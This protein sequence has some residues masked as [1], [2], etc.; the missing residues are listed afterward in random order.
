MHEESRSAESQP[1]R[2]AQ[3]VR[4]STDHQQYSTENQ[5]AAIKKYAESNGMIIVKTYAD[6]GKSGLNIDGRAA[7]ASLIRDIQIGLVNFTAVLIY[8]VSRWGRFQDVDESAHYEYICTKAGI[9]IIC[10]ESFENDGTPVSAMIKGIKRAMAGEYSRELSAKVF[11]GQCRLITLGYRQG[12]PAGYGLRRQLVG[13][14]GEN[15]GILKKGQQKS[16]Q[17][18][19]V[20]LVPG[21][22]E[23]ITVV[24]RIYHFFVQQGMSENDIASVL[25][26]EDVLTDLDHKWTRSTVHQVLTNEKYIGNNVYNRVSF[27]LKKHRVHNPR[28]GWIRVES[29]FI[30]VVDRALFLRAALIISNRSVRLSAEQMLIGLRNLYIKTGVLSG[31]IID[32][33]DGMPS[34]S[35]YRARFGSLIRAYLLVGYRPLRDYRYI[36]I[37]RDLRQLHPK[38]ISNIVA[39]LERIGAWVVHIKENALL[40]VNGEFTL[41]IILVR[42]MQTPGGFNRWRMRFDTELSPDITLAVRMDASNTEALDYYLLPQLDQIVIPN[43]VAEENGLWLDAYRFDTLDALYGI[44]ART[45]I[46]KAA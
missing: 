18:D 38:I 21:P 12:G 29:V 44:A 14:K 24:Q 11:A 32:E 5:T 17:T 7:L 30:P 28:E 41:S 27:K 43:K 26:A 16:L 19:R 34:S 3:Y 6:E 9:R 10:A 37:N 8:D 33:Q 1:I 31:L 22:A 13:D 36:E 35:A 39:G 25:N 45:L 4:M 46:S 20:I 42:C 23:E 40:H 15:K 2:V